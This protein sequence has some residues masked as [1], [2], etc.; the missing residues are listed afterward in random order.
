[1]KWITHQTGAL[2]GAIALQLPMASVLMVI[3]G[4]ILPDLADLKM[5]RLGDGGRHRQK[6]FSKIHR[7][8]T[9]WFGWWLG[10]LFLAL[11]FP[12]PSLIRDLVA[13]LALGAFSHV[14]LDLL[15]PKGIPL[16]PFGRKL[17]VATPVCSTGTYGEWLFLALLVSAGIIFIFNSILPLLRA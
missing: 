3:P 11:A 10:L 2:L 1:M 5:A 9:H 16:L 15:N 14:L 4:A 17:R 12:L 13:G 6:V 8:T 7:G